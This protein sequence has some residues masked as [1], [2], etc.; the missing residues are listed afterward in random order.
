[1]K[2]IAA[3]SAAVVGAST[4]FAAATPLEKRGLP[5]VTVKGNGSLPQRFLTIYD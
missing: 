2:G 4:A 5:A 1:M 3:L